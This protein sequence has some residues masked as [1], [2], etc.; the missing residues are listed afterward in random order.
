VNTLSWNWIDLVA[1][2]YVVYGTWLGWRQGLSRELPRLI[3]VAVFVL[4][5]FS[6]LRWTSRAMESAAA[7]SVFQASVL[8][9][10][11]LYIGAFYL[12]KNWRYQVQMWLD[13]RFQEL[14]RRK[15]G[16]CAGLFRTAMIAGF[17]VVYFGLWKVGFIHRTFAERSFFGRALTTCVLPVYKNFFETEEGKKPLPVTETTTSSEPQGHFPS[18]GSR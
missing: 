4:T 11:F 18:K 17:I 3:A 9:I 14:Q 6:L 8:S 2:A 16:A 13:C 15:Y 12:L 10:P 1:L 7:L 5:G